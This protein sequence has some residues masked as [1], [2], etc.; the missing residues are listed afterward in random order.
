MVYALA[1]GMGSDVEPIRGIVTVELDGTGSRVIETVA[2]SAGN[3]LYLTPSP[4]GRVV[5]ATHAFADGQ[6]SAWT[7]SGGGFSRLGDARASGGG[8]PCHLTVHPAGRHLLTA[9]YATGSVAVH[10]L[11]TDGSL[12][13]AS[14]VIDHHGSGPETARQEGPHPHM[15][16]CDPGADPERGDVLVCDLGTDRVYRYR[17]DVTAGRL[18]EMEQITMP[19]GTG[20]RHLAVRGRYAYVVG[21]LA[22]TLTVID[23]AENPSAVLTTVETQVEPGPERSQPSAVT[24]SGDGHV[25]YVLNRGPDTVACF[26]VTGPEVRLLAEVSAGGGPPWDAVIDDGHLYVANQR[27]NAVTVLRIDASTGV[28]EPT[29]HALQV[30]GA[31]CIT[32]VPLLG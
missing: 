14:Q 6:V 15:V 22:S 8:T 9:N 29:G 20:P 32:P 21:E 19:P 5:Y 24:M 11:G 18:T 13:E 26:S 23:L 16:L 2:S 27:S 10:P 28:P 4:D 12:A 7:R 3:C 17:L 31:V 30:P 25:L 1:S